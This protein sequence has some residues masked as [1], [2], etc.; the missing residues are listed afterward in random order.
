MKYIDPHIHMISRSTDD[1][2]RM[3]QAGCVAITE[4]AFWA[5]FD[6]S[7]PRGFYDYFRHLTEQEPRRAAEYGIQHFCWICINPK[8]AEDA[9]FAREVIAIIPEFLDKPNVLGIG[10]IGLNKNSRNELAIFE[11]QLALAV[12]VDACQPDDLARPNGKARPFDSV[13]AAISLDDQAIYPQHFAAQ[14]QRRRLVYRKRVPDDQLRQLCRSGL[15]D[16]ELG[17]LHACSQDG[18]AIAV[19]H[20]LRQSVRHDDD[21]RAFGCQLTQACEQRI[22]VRRREH[23]GRLV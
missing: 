19:G 10:E 1:Y 4:P 22:G 14:I 18:D 3:A 9:V 6:R 2:Q 21:R 5:G 11:E 13:V 23:R 12:S 16:G 7:S 17:Y 15:A 8:E 20:H